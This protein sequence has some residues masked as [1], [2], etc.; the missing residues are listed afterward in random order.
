MS[1]LMLLDWKRRKRSTG[2]WSATFFLHVEGSSLQFNID[3]RETGLVKKHYHVSFNLIEKF[4]CKSYTTSFIRE[5]D[6]LNAEFIWESR[7][8]IQIL[9]I[10]YTGFKQFSE[11]TRPQDI[12]KQALNTHACFFLY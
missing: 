8:N 7:A 6:F 11:K 3:S 1:E 2:K 5:K 9:V 12:H 10:K 4:K